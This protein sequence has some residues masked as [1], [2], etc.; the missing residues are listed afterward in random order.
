MPSLGFQGSLRW[1]AEVSEQ[2]GAVRFGFRPGVRL[3]MSANGS[4]P[5]TK[6]DR[7]DMGPG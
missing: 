6:S 2:E 5:I 1:E 4:L 7:R 3:L